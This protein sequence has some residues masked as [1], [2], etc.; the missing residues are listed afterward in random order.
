M[1]N[2]YHKQN[3]LNTWLYNRNENRQYSFQSYYDTGVYNSYKDLISF[4]K[5][6]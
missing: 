6:L 5:K 3:I 2:L 4:A 1:G